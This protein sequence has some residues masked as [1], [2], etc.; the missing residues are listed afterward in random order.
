MASV[1][2]T[3]AK[4]ARLVHRKNPYWQGVSGGRGGVS[5][6]YRT[7]KRGSGSWVAKVVIH[8]QRLEER[9]GAADGDSATPGAIGYRKAVAATL[10]WSQRQYEAHR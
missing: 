10:E 5:L 9:I 7:A 2:D 8:G 6:G 1:I 4:R 3:P